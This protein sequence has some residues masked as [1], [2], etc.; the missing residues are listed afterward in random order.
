MPTTRPSPPSQ[1]IPEATWEHFE[2]YEHVKEAISSLPGH[3]TTETYIILVRFFQ[4]VCR[5]K[6]YSKN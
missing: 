6:R 2:L 1:I 3:F 4:N 5:I